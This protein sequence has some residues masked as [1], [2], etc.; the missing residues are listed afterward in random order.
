MRTK[1]RH[2]ALFYSR[3][4]FDVTRRLHRFVM[5]AAHALDFDRARGKAHSPFI[6]VELPTHTCPGY[7]T[8]VL[9][10]VWTR[11]VTREVSLGMSL[12]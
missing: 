5:R 12:R 4:R 1:V 9:G 11:T 10:C 2:H 6:Q 8:A 3:D 7:A